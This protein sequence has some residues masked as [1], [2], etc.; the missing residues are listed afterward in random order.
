[1][2]RRFVCNHERVDS[3]FPASTTTRW[4]DVS[5]QTFELAMV[6]DG[7]DYCY[8]LQ[9]EHDKEERKCRVEKEYVTCDGNFLF[10]SENGKVCAVR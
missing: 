1:M 2:I 8:G 5:T 9:I 4:M 10:Q 3:F 7:K 6:I